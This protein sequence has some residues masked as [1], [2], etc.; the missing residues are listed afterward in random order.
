[1]KPTRT[2]L[3]AVAA[4]LSTIAIAA[5]VRTASADT[6]VPATV[7]GPTFIT[8]AP[9]TFINTPTPRSPPATTRWGANSARDA[10]DGVT[11]CIAFAPPALQ[12]LYQRLPLRM[13]AAKL[14]LPLDGATRALPERTGRP[15][16]GTDGLG[17]GW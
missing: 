14:G 3:V 8:S 7:I 9:A 1:M 2:R 17:Y 12:D 16:G 13:S 10:S 4:A 5:S 11:F 15:A 6:V